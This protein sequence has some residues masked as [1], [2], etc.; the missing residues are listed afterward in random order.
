M[1]APPTGAPSRIVHSNPALSATFTPPPIATSKPA[2]R[3][4]VDIAD[5]VAVSAALHAAVAGKPP[6]SW[7]NALDIR[8]VDARQVTF[9]LRPGQRGRFAFVSNP[10]QQGRLESLLREVLGVT[11]RIDIEQPVADG[12]DDT[13]PAGAGQSLD[14]QAALAMPLVREVME[15]FNDA[16]IVDIRKEPAATPDSRG[17]NV[18]ADASTPDALKDIEEGPMLADDDQLF[19]EESDDV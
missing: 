19:Q 18:D 5:P 7:V 11:M 14:R 15:V 17:T 10:R 9:A 16:V 3:A 8:R 13:T 6:L 2:A 1:T 4:E 12:G